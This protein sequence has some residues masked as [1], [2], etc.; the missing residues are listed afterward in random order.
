VSDFPVTDRRATRTGAGGLVVGQSVAEAKAMSRS[1]EVALNRG[2]G[3]PVMTDTTEGR[4]MAVQRLSSQRVASAF[5]GVGGDVNFAIQRPRD[6]L[7][8]MSQNNMQYDL[9]NPTHMAQLRLL[10]RYI[11]RTHSLMAAAIDIYAKWP[12]VGMEF[13]CKDSE[14]VDFYSE[15]FIEQLDYEEY[16]GDIGREFWTVGE[17]WPLGSFNED[18]GVWEDDELLNPDDVFVEKSPF[19]KDPRFTIRLPESLRRVLQTGQPA[20]EY[21]ALMRSYPELKAY[22]SEQARMPV[23]NILLKQ[24]RFKADAFH[25]RGVPIMERALRPLLQEEML[26]S[27]QDAIAD[28]LYTPLILAKIGASAQDLGTQQPWVPTPGQIADFESALDIALA[29][30][31]RV[32][33]TH[34]A[35]DMSTVFG[36]ETMPNL[37]ADFERLAEKQL[38]AFGLS[39]TMLSGAGSGETY[40][41]DALNRDLISQLLSTYQRYIKRFVKDRCLVVAEAQEHY[42]YDERGGKKYVKMEE[43]LVVDP[44]SGE[45]KVIEQPKLLVP[46]LK[47]QTMNMKDDESQR[48]FYEALRAQ[49]VPISMKTR[50]V[51]VPIDLKDE[52][53]ATRE[54]QIE[55]AVE[56]A[57]T[58]KQ[59]YMRLLAENLP[60]PED[61]EKEFQAKALQ[62]KHPEPA[63]P[64]RVPQLGVDDMDHSSLVPTPEDLMV[65]PGQPLPDESG[66]TVNNVIPL[67]TN[68]ML[69]RTR[70]AESDEMRASM[71]KPAALYTEAYVD[72][73]GETQTIEIGEGSLLFGPKHVG[74]RVLAAKTEDNP[75]GW[76]DP[77]RPIGEAEETG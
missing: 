8:Y 23:S 35:V 49:G 64:T 21:A 10:C 25:H 46:D 74:R 12:I 22:T 67:P 9:N 62:A 26:N 60:I 30:D 52:I 29:A 1:A 17:A 69:T 55:L 61:L 59:T 76:I 11:Y 47:L 51:N 44:E 54:E 20:H 7:Y 63:Q 3:G 41:A 31:F 68:Q 24:L 39:K 57:Q 45:K 5:G 13:V 15:L 6:P 28:R 34:F 73:A 70:P 16:L 75:D 58:R 77:N 56:A 38:Q 2:R 33:T 53:E 37:D 72:E 65:P 66:S 27:A 50:L 18:L 32:L 19:L 36:R 43:V 4:R 40:A 71:P 48:Q 14:I 42:D